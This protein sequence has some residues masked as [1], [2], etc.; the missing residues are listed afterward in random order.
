MI[1][2]HGI[3]VAQNVAHSEKVSSYFWVQGNYLLVEQILPL[4]RL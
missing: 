2:I 1:R 3:Q 4:T